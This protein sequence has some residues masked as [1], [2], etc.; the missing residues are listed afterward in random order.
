MSDS[1]ELSLDGVERRSLADFTEQAYLNYSMYVIM[2]RALPHIGDGLKPVQRRIV[3]AMSELGLDADSKHK[4][5]ARTVGDVLGKFH[6]H[7]DSACYEAMVLMAQPFSYRYTLV[8]G[9]GNWGA[10][11]DPKSFAAM[12]YTEARLSRYSEVLLSELG[13]GTVDWVPN[14]DGTLQEPAVLPARLP[15]ILLNGT[16]GIAVGMATDVPPHNL[17]EVASACVRL[18]DEPKA[19][20]EQLCEHIQGPDY[21]TEAEIVTPRADIQKIYES[22]KGSIRMRAV[23]RIE[24]GDIVVTALPH[25]VSGAKVLEQIAAQMQAK[26]LPMVADLRDESDHENPCRIVI[27]PRSNRVDA[28]ELMQ[29]LFATT[30]LESTYRVNVNII[31]LDGRP[32]LKNL[33]ALLLEWL[34]YRIGTVRRRLQHRLDKVE[35]RLHLL[36]GLL[37][38]F[39]NLDEVIHIIR[40][41]EHPKQALIARFD[42]TEIQ[43]DYILETRLR[44]LA[45]LEEM[46]IRGEQDELLK[47]QKQLQALL[48]SDT[49]LRKLVRRE[50]IKD[51]ETYG[52]DRRSP[53]VERAEAKALSENEL[54]PTEPVTVVLSEKGWVR[55]AKGHDI[56]ATGL[57]YK[58][59]D[60]FKAAAAGR[61]NQFAVLIDSTGRSY[62]LAAHSLPSARGQGEPLTGRLTPPPGATFECV[63]LPED[64]A[65]YVVASDAGY[66]FVVKGE[67]LQ[68]K[69]KAGKG[70]LSLPNGA[71]VMTPRP[72]T[73]REQDWLAAVTTEGRLL[74]FKVADLPQLGKGKGNKIIGVPG[75]RVAS[76]EEYVTD[77]AVISEGSTLV[78]QAG[79]RTLSLKPD[80]LEHYKGE[81]GRRGSK[82]PR[83][84]QRVDGLLVETPA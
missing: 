73:D 20:I 40:T 65:L 23:Y 4:K 7:G 61:S 32:Q 53:I 77:L 36:E 41:E 29:H 11:D 62:S 43:A 58:A 34:E 55:C 35:K 79:K 1:L 46:K 59:G 25:Q 26:K 24:D 57:S 82:L 14:F 66:G 64:D 31:G 21:P 16:T 74:V 71:K 5:S 33:R 30:D 75:D 50:L 38:A 37:T 28:A 78:L 19:T 2:D 27:I 83:G 45:R 17:R 80:D 49:K 9:Q 56:D 8:D 72:V 52:D 60:G 6:P 51:A 22:G 70:L 63:L 3:Y 42:L 54:M 84:F 81:R 15:N 76:R 39:L 47:E 68:A 48:G 12:R 10:P 13:Q 69:N 44:Q 18:L 67:D